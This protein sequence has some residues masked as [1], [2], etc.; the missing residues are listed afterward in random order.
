M[1]SK[2][3]RDRGSSS[4]ESPPALVPRRQRSGECLA[5]AQP[6]CLPR[7]P[8]CGQGRARRS[9]PHQRS[10]REWPLS[11]TRARMQRSP[12]GQAMPGTGPLKNPD[13]CAEQVTLLV[14]STT[15]PLR[16]ALTVHATGRAPPTETTSSCQAGATPAPGC[17]TQ[18]LSMVAVS[19]P[20]AW[21]TVWSILTVC[22]SACNAEE[23]LCPYQHACTKLG[24]QVLVA[25]HAGNGLLWHVGA[26]IAV[27][28][29]DH[30]LRHRW[31][32]GPASQSC[33][34]R[35]CRATP[36]TLVMLSSRYRLE[37]L[38]VLQLFLVQAASS[39]DDDSDQ[40]TR[41]RE[42]ERDV[43]QA[44]FN[45]AEVAVRCAERG[46]PAQSE[47]EE[48]LRPPRVCT[49]DIKIDHIRPD[50]G[51]QSASGRRVLQV[52]RPAAAAAAEPS[53]VPKKG[54]SIQAHRSS[55]GQGFASTG[56]RA[57]PQQRLS[58]ARSSG[59][60]E[61]EPTERPDRRHSIS[62]H[63]PVPKP[64]PPEAQPARESLS[65][66]GPETASMFAALPAGCYPVAGHTHPW[67]PPGRGEVHLCHEG[68][69]TALVQTCCI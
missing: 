1:L 35:H 65:R 50:H 6:C 22:A 4:P 29:V 37:H 23:R 67:Y 61:S 60:T 21:C 41:E 24:A 3:G 43:A 13:R 58:T 27:L 20:L 42:R 47:S 51:F 66:A 33:S 49:S 63:R 68:A 26:L 10:M 52:K 30:D 46:S 25:R 55:S 56:P 19:L 11:L 7:T 39:P 17:L 36:R 5:C 9:A 40:E 14:P 18:Q 69:H 15:C 57:R 2:R 62:A 48:G 16:E 12:P 53:G 34:L 31:S 54:S 28:P 38:Q 44:L 32:V 59:A 8:A 45:L 64:Q